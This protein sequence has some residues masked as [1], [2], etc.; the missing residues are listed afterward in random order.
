MNQQKQD[1]DALQKVIE[2]KKLTEKG[3]NHSPR[4]VSQ[5]LPMQSGNAQLHH[6]QH[7]PAHQL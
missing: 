7:S 5:K 1:S 3:K 4:L 6:A 2:K